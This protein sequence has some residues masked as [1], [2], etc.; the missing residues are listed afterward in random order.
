MTDAAFLPIK[1][2]PD[3]HRDHRGT[4]SL[5]V[6]DIEHPKNKIN[7]PAINGILEPFVQRLQFKP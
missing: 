5:P 2:W 7:Y 1:A 4:Q 6:N 3:P